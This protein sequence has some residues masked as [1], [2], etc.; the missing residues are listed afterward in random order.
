MPLLRFLELPDLL[1]KFEFAT[2]QDIIWWECLR[3][4]PITL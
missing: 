4:R 2:L 3:G 1:L